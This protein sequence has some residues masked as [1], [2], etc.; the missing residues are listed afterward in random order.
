M[1]TTIRK[2]LQAYYVDEKPMMGDV[3]FKNKQVT[4]FNTSTQNRDTI[5]V[6]FIPGDW[7]MAPIDSEIE[8]RPNMAAAADLIFRFAEHIQTWRNKT[9]SDAYFPAEIL[10]NA[11]RQFLAEM[12]GG[13]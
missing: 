4:N 10:L 11:A 9:S 3:F 13:E 6:I 5:E 7:E 2:W 1:K 8:V 12:E